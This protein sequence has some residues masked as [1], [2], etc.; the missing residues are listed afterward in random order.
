MIFADCENEKRIAMM[1]GPSLVN[2]LLQ[3]LTYFI[4]EINEERPLRLE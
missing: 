1:K 4:F 2:D 3:S